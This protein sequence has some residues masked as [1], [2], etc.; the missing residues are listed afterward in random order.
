MEKEALLTSGEFRGEGRFGVGPTVE[1]HRGQSHVL[2]AVTLSLSAVS[3]A[4][5]PARTSQAL[6]M[7]LA[8]QRWEGRKSQAKALSLQS[9]GVI[10][11]V[12]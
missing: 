8:G 5:W 7:G 12:P 3:P 6:I 9:A 4:A 10:L 1:N 11:S 2:F